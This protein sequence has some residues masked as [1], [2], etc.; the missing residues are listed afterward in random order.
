MMPRPADQLIGRISLDATGG[1]AF[2]EL[3]IR[4]L[5]AIARTGSIS[6]AAKT[7][8]LSYKAAWDAVE[9]MNSLAPEPLVQRV[10]GGRQGGGS[11][12]TAYGLRMI[13]MYRALEIET[14]AALERVSTRLGEDGPLDVA[15]YRALMQ[16]LSMKTSAR[17]QFSG[18]IV[19]LR[20][21]GVDFEVGLRVDAAA[22]ITATITR[23]SAQRLSLAIGKEVLAL[24]K[25]SSVELCAEDAA[26]PG[27]AGNRLCGVISAIH[28]GTANDELGLVL[29]SGRCLTAVMPHGERVARGLAQG[30]AACALFKASSVIL[31]VHD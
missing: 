26:A 16:P 18:P 3:R 12:L 5:E 27:V 21:G 10:T 14:R 2:S 19:A 30:G 8:P 29:A 11:R 31:A 25:S 9:A 24:V 15:G 17:N 7:V 4:L 20:D 22:E 23:A 28:E 1:T 13:A 6:Q